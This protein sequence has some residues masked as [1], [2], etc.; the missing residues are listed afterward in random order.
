VDRLLSVSRLE[1]ERVSIYDR[2]AKSE[3]QFWLGI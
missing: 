2:E 1:K 3:E